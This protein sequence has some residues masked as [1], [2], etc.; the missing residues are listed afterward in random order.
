MSVKIYSVNS[1]KDKRKNTEE[2]VKLKLNIKLV[3]IYPNIRV[4]IKNIKGLNYLG[5]R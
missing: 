5:K 4:T 3:K 2:C 1:N